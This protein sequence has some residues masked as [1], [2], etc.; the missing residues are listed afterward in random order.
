[1]EPRFGHDFSKVRVHTDAKAAESAQAVNARA[2]TVGRHV[3]FASGKYAPYTPDGKRLL[4]HEL[5]HTLQQ[6]NAP[7][8]VSAPLRVTA[9]ND[10]HET[11][12][13]RIARGVSRDVDR[14]FVT[15]RGV[16]V[17]RPAGAT[18]A[19][20]GAPA[21]ASSSGVGVSPASVLAQQRTAGNQAVTTLLARAPGDPAPDSP[22]VADARR[23]LR[24]AEE[25][26]KDL[27]EEVRGGRQLGSGR[28]RRDTSRLKRRLRE[29]A[30]RSPAGAS[31]PVAKRAAELLG[32]I[33]DLDNDLRA[34]QI[35][36]ER[37][38]GET[39][40]DERAKK[41]AKEKPPEAQKFDKARPDK[42]AKTTKTP[43][44]SKTPPNVKV[45]TV[46][47]TPIV[48]KTPPLTKTAAPVRKPVVP[49]STKPPPPKPLSS[50]GSAK[51]WGRVTPFSAAMIYLDLH[52]VHFKALA[53]V[54]ARVE[55]AKNIVNYIDELEKGAR[56]LNKAV[57]AQ[58]S[59]EYDLP[60]YPVQSFEDD[61]HA[62]Q[63]PLGALWITEAELQ[64]VREYHD[65]AGR[66]F[67]DAWDARTVLE[68]T[69]AGWDSVNA[70]AKK[71]RDFTRKA[72][73]EAIIMLDLRF[74]NEGGSFR[75]YVA[76]TRDTAW[77][78][79]Q[80]AQAKFYVAKDI[81]ESTGQMPAKKP[82]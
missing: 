62:E 73:S 57:E 78:V 4:A 36:R 66:I 74:S 79:E 17:D 54:K 26:A 2:F 7:A 12:A 63:R 65:A 29:I 8:A 37:A 24:E 77:R 75:A 14:G 18:P 16:R 81:L 52:A 38:R 55:F 10:S 41:K 30:N 67:S 58:R 69:L 82:T 42:T 61:P 33:E 71:L 25:V 20:A 72:V 64:Y 5:A 34:R 60:Q 13:D 46:P 51:S 56:A 6:W 11:E 21:P 50:L 19:R 45:P 9:P 23:V 40:R 28:R 48:P 44:A 80:W 32:Q 22:T 35:E 53:S 43:P 76:E 31:D 3:V 47:K 68:R 1:M 59:A 15:T 39:K 70:E 27:V 49:T